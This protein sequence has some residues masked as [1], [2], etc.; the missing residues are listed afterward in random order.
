MLEEFEVRDVEVAGV[1]IRTA[2]S[3]RGPAVLL[4]HGY[5]E[6][7]VMWHRVAP[8]LAQ[9]NTV[10]LA[11]LR[12]YGDSS[13]PSPTPDHSTYSKRAMGADQIGLMERLGFETFAVVGHD[14][15]ARVA[16]RMCLDHP[17]R[18][19]RVA[20]L[21][22]VPTL[23]VL[24]HVDR[25]LAQT[26]YHWF[27]LAQE[28]D[29]PERMIGSDPGTTSAASWPNGQGLASGVSRPKHSTST[30]AASATQRSFEPRA[31]T[32][33]PVPPS[34]SST[35]TP[36]G[37]PADEWNVRPS[38]SGVPTASSDARTTSSRCGARMPPT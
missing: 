23:H 34:I 13:R 6:S 24:T 18:V 31:R 30:S 26:Y 32:T 36:T 37:L 7:H 19:T 25:H 4:L 2:I 35:M 38:C 17:E 10:V 14:R 33:G 29:L 11:D 15:G 28:P 22:I 9:R 20:F 21:D 1:R 16:H 5:P 27:F 3:G 12:G 8:R